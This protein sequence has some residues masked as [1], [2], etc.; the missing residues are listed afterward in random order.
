MVLFALGN[1]P[2]VH[3]RVRK[4]INAIIK[5]DE[6]ITL[7]NL[8]KLTYIDWIQYEITRLYGPVNGI[9]F[10]DA[11]E[12]NYLKDVPISKGTLVTTQPVGNHF[13]PKYFKDPFEFRPERW[14]SECDGIHPF[15]FVG[16]SAGIRTCIGKQLNHV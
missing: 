10:R 5:S 2:E 1:H 16:F 8:K 7:E 15:A 11:A 12:D 14:E 13:N 6:D 9:L 3:S 4:E